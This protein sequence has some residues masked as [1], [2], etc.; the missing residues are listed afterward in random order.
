[1]TED[2]KRGPEIDEALLRAEFNAFESAQ[3]HAPPPAAAE[4]IKTIVSRDLN[5]T[6]WRVLVR[7]FGI[8]ACAG[9]LT[10]LICPHMGLGYGNMFGLMGI[11]MKLG[12]HFC[13]ALCGAIFVGFGSLLAALVLRPEELRVIREE[14]L[15][16][17]TVISASFLGLFVCAG[18]PAFSILG[19]SWMTGAVIGGLSTFEAAARFRFLVLELN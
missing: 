12:D 4:A 2:S 13:Q 17:F 5:P 6:F 19:L 18:A 8:T 1:M 11:I 14:R 7:L 15:L 9:A 3:Q 10:L 16:Q